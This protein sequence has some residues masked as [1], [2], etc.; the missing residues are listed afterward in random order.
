MSV[1]VY[2]HRTQTMT[3][4]T[5]AYSGNSHPAG[6][7]MKIHR[8]KE[9]PHAGSLL[10]VVSNVVGM[11]EEFRAWIERGADKE[12]WAPNDPSFEALLVK[13]NGEIF[14]FDDA[15][16]CA[17]PMVG[18][19]FTIGSGRKYAYG[20]LMAGADAKAAVEVAIACDTWCGGPVAQ[21]SLHEPLTSDQ[22]QPELPFDLASF[23]TGAKLSNAPVAE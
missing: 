21:I 10:G 4:D 9:G 20:A 6:H 13:P 23:S 8:I 11:P 15:Y 17:G 18:S 16:Y 19:F 22:A 1:V 3:A 12:D 14:L 2:D 5:R 7:K